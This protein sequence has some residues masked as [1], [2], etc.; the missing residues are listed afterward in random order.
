M[1]TLV[2]DKNK[3]LHKLRYLPPVYYINLDEQSDR[4]DHIEDHFNYWGVK[5][6]T[7]ISA[8]DGRNDDLS[9]IIKGRYPENMTSKEVGCTTSHLKAIRHWY[10]NSDSSYALI[11][12]DD[13]DLDVV[14]CWNFSWN[15]FM[16]NLPYDWDV[17]QLAIICTGSIHIKLHKR[18]VNDFSTACYMINRHHAEKLLKF[19]ERDGKYKLDNGSR[20]RAVA[21]DLIYN[22]GNTYSMP[23]FLYKLELGSSIHPEHIDAIHKGNRESQFNWWQQEGIKYDIKDLMNYDP[24]LGRISPQET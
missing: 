8:Y 3:A 2:L 21:N 11:M 24:Y 9:D 17:V 13:I 12:E 19:H 20:P 5:D 16:A 10:D 22:S 7:R 4:K 14:R 6:Y 1:E 23:I 15:E 18:F